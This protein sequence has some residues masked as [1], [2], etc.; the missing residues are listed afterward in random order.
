MSCMAAGSFNNFPGDI[1]SP[2]EKKLI[3]LTIMKLV[4]H[5]EIPPNI[6]AARKGN[7]NLGNKFDTNANTVRV[8][9]LLTMT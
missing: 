2:R 7:V 3:S 5:T 8:H 9:S 1:D 6:I 4:H